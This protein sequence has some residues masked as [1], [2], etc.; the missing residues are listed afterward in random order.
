MYRKSPLTAKSQLS[1]PARVP[2][3]ILHP[4]VALVLTLLVGLAGLIPAA[5]AQTY[6][7]TDLGTLGGT[8]SSGSGIN[9]SGKVTG[10]ST[11]AVGLAPHAFISDG[12][13]MTDL[14]TLGGTYSEGFGI[15]SRGQVTGGSSIA[16]DVTTH[17]FIS[18]GTT[19]T[20]LG[21]LGGTISEGLGINDRGQVTGDAHTATEVIHAFISDGTTMTD[22]GTLGGTNCVFCSVGSGINAGGQVTGS[23]ATAGNTAHAFISDGTTMTDLGTLGGTSSE[24]FAINASGQVTGDSDTAGNAAVHA[25]ISDGTTMTDLGTLGGTDSAGNA[26]NASGWVTGDSTTTPGIPY[27]HAFLYSNGSMKDLNSLVDPGNALSTYVTLSAGRAINDSGWI[28]AEG[29]DSRTHQLHAYLLTPVTAPPTAVAGLN[30]SIAV[31]QT[32]TL[33]GTGSYAPDT[34]SASLL[35]A[36][37]FVSLPSASAATLSGADTST[38]SFLADAPGTY[39]VQLIV[40]DPNSGLPS[41][42]SQLSISSL[43][44]APTADAGPT[45]AAVVRTRVTLAGSGVDPSGLPLSYAWTLLSKP[46]GS[47]AALAAADT[48]SPSFTA[49]RAGRYTAGLVVSDT[50]GSSPQ[51]TVTI[52]AIRA[53][54]YAEQQIAGALNY[55]AALPASQFDVP[56]HRRAL[57]RLLHQ[58]IDAIEHH[59]FARAEGKLQRSLIRTDGSPLRG[60]IDGPGP[61]MDW[62][63]DPTAQAAAYQ[64]LSNALST[65]PP[66][67]VGD[68]D[69]FHNDGV[70]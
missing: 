11:L 59:R 21:T 16:G 57:T 2:G 37:S 14:G 48:A 10:S 6:S 27:R 33:D 50:F 67:A 68:M 41:A 24:G 17:A 8:A 18:D 42:P 53:D 19:M 1:A 12:T 31:G 38:P 55:I 5:N 64:A 66:A 29:Q 44:V 43:Y 51:A 32:V 22:L 40:T 62:I 47:A 45:Q 26:I 46:R 54:D 56:G 61:G 63:I 65:L 69:D 4:R 36:W 35:Y 13:A 30:Q 39:V 9:A 23:A 3:A 58:A 52:S 49:D 70:D 20:D 34:P 25:F 28:V 60:A 7:L 15:N